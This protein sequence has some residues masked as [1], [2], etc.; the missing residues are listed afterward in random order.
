MLSLMYQYHH[1]RHQLARWSYVQTVRVI[2]QQAGTQT[3]SPT[4]LVVQWIA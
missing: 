2:L 4:C 1:C 3:E